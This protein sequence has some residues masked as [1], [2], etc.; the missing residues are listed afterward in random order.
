MPAGRRTLWLSIAGAVLG[1]LAQPPLAWSLLGWFAMVPWLL[2]ATEPRRL[3]RRDYLAMYLASALLWLALLEGVRLAHP[4]QY[5][6]WVVLSGYLGVYLP[7]FVASVRGMIGSR[8]RVPLT[9]ASVAAGIGLE[10]IRNY[11]VTGFG[12]AMLGHTQADQPLVIQVADLGGTYAVSGLLYA[13]AAGIVSLWRGWRPSSPASFDEQHLGET[14]AIGPPSGRWRWFDVSLA[15]GIV[16]AGLA[17]GAVCLATVGAAPDSRREIAASRSRRPLR[18]ALLQANAPARFEVDLNRDMRAFSLYARLSV[19]AITKQRGDLELII[20]PESIF[21]AG[22]PYYMVDGKLNPPREVG[23]STEEFEFA[24][25]QRQDAFQRRLDDLLSALAEPDN[26][27]ALLLG[28][29]AILFRPGAMQQLNSALHVSGDGVVC[30][31]YAKQHLVMFGEYLPGAGWFPWLARATPLGAG[32]TAGSEPRAFDVRGW[33]IAPSICFETVVERVVQR[34]FARLAAAGK[35]PDVLVNQTND[36]WFRG[37]G[38]VGLHRAC[39]ILLATALRRP[40]LSAGN[41]GPTLW[42]DPW[43]RVQAEAPFTAQQ[44]VFAELTD[45]RPFP[46]ALYQRFGDWFAIPLAVVAVA[47]LLSGWRRS[48]ASARSAGTR[49]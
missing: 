4:A 38:V 2:I 17:Y 46:T 25:R 48:G 19:D 39:A 9:L 15:L 13:G 20:W 8:I 16:V 44:V 31:W 36:A 11:F 22:L 14:M 28:C 42:V 47:G 5:V 33:R 26:R 49:G 43:G 24:I 35:P 45:E 23:L 21:T 7:L 3:V 18:V 1:W 27:P 30:D 10:W 34:S 29:A 6:G 12:A 41:G 40:M 32:L 37:H